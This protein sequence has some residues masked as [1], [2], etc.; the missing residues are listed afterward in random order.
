MNLVRQIRFLQVLIAVATGSK[1]DSACNLLHSL[2]SDKVVFPGSGP[3]NESIG[4]YAYAGA[5]VLP[6]CVAAP[7]STAD[8]SLIVKTLG[9]C[10]SVPFAIRSG[11]HSSNKGTISSCFYVAVLLLTFLVGFANAENG[12]TIDLRAI[13]EVQLSEHDGTVSIGAGALSQPVYDA[14]EPKGLSVQAGRIGDVGVGG[15]ITNGM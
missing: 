13:D 3:Y 1:V 2:L 4:S 10:D 7:A 8:V 12:I 15:L 14:V 11:G 5:R 6:T 9:E